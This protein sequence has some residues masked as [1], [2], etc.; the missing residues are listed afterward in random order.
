MISKIKSRMFMMNLKNGKWKRN[1]I[2]FI[3]EEI[4]SWLSSFHKLTRSPFT[5]P[6]KVTKELFNFLR[7]PPIAT[8]QNAEV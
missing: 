4:C 6:T 1:I 3:A 2:V 5:P 7:L 8:P